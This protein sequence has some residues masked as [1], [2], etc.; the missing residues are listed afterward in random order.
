MDVQ[1]VELAVEVLGL[2]VKAAR[3][4]VQGLECRV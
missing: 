3:F 1:Y 2:R 4:R